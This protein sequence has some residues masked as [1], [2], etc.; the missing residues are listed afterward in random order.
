MKPVVRIF[1]GPGER[2]EEIV[3]I[4]RG[5]EVR[6]TVCFHEH[7]LASLLL[8]ERPED[9]LSGTFFHGLDKRGG[10]MC[11]MKRN[12]RELAGFDPSHNVL[13]SRGGDFSVAHMSPPNQDITCI[14]HFCA[15]SWVGSS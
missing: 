10:P 3:V 12:Q 4:R 8:A 5:V 15:Q 7:G 1:S 6:I 2:R 14:E 9:I 11:R 13:A